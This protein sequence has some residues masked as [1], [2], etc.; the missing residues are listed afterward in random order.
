MKKLEVY[1][2]I[3]T[4]IFAAV[5]LIM[6]FI[7]FLGFITIGP[8]SMTL[9]HIPVL[10]GVFLLPKR[11]SWV[12]G[13]FF[14]LGSFIRA[15]ANTGV[16]D[17]AF[18]NPLTSILP[19][20]LFAIAAAWLFELFKYLSTKFKNQ[21]VIFFGLVSALT[22]MG[23]YYGGVA[24]ATNFSWSQSITLPIFLLLGILFLTAYY[25][26]LQRLNKPLLIFIPT[27]LLL[28]TV[29]HTIL[30]LAAVG[31]FSYDFISQ[32]YASTSE[33]IDFIF[34]AAMSNGLL[35]AILAVLVGAPIIYTLKQ[36]SFIKK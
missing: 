31:L 26:T 27:T 8:I 35:E 16:M 12:L 21:D 19:R 33:I 22:M 32:F 6:S 9:I 18:Q 3:L 14:G 13:L 23:F 20:I 10:I 11:Y 30:T 29:I 7:P 28:A 17:P 24:A 25:Y 1:D 36:S 2:L 4:S 34:V 15:F 5:I